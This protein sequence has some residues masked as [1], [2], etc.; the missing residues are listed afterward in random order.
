M[1]KRNDEMGKEAKG[2][3]DSSS[4]KKMRGKDVGS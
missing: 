1:K 4:V 2:E 3:D